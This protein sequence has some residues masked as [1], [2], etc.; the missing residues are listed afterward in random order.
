MRSTSAW[1][2]TTY[3]ASIAHAEMLMRA[4]AAVAADSRD[5]R[6]SRRWRRA[7]ARR[8]ASR[9]RRR[10]RQTAL[11]KRLTARIGEAGGRVHLGRSRND[12][13]LTALRLY[14]RDAVEQLSR[15]ALA[16]A[17]ALDALARARRHDR[18][19][20]LHP[21]AAGDAE[22]GRAVGGG[23]AA[24]IRDDARAAPCT[25]AWRR[26][27]SAPPRAMARRACR[28]TA[29]PRAQA[30]GFAEVQEP[31]TAVQLSRGKAEASC[32]SRSRC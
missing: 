9:A 12:Q 1:C 17:E 29:R 21:H 27:R 16:V 7:R 32:C 3:A 23:F 22:F 2:P 14:L 6:G 19:A 8:V 13:V 18:A 31:V 26:A 15:G 11:E 10:G 25:G 4:A 28:S 5:P 20:R 30:L 24:E